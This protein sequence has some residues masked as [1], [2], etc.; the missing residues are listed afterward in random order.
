M[1]E[2]RVCIAYSVLRIL[3]CLRIKTTKGNKRNPIKT[4][5]TFSVRSQVLYTPKVLKPEKSSLAIETQKQTENE[6]QYRLTHNTVCND[7]V[8]DVM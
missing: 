4:K 5:T 2:L 3:T 6:W 1:L 7:D 8:G